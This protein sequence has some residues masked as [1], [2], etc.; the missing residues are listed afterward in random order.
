[1]EINGKKLIVSRKKSKML[2]VNRKGKTPL[3]PSFHC[4]PPSRLWVTTI[5]L[6][7]WDPVTGFL[8]RVGGD[9]PRTE[10]PVPSTFHHL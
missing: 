9:T 8:V 6:I 7:L 10:C 2:T 5:F 4:L 3:R 1:M